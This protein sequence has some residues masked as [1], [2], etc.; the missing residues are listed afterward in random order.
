MIIIIFWYVLY[1]SNDKN[2]IVCVGYSKVSRPKGV[3]NTNKLKILYDY[4]RHALHMPTVLFITCY[5]YTY[6]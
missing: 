2:L 3:E 5:T 1:G 4:S 6:T